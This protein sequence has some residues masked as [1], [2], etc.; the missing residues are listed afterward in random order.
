M[1]EKRVV[2][3]NTHSAYVM[4]KEDEFLYKL[5]Q[6]P[7]RNAGARLT[8]DSRV[9]NVGASH[10]TFISHAADADLSANW[11]EKPPAGKEY[12]AA[13]TEEQLLYE[14]DLPSHHD[15][16]T[17][18]DF[19]IEKEIP[20]LS[21]PVYTGV[22]KE[23]QIYPNE[24][25]FD[26]DYEAEP[27]LQVLMTRILE[28]SRVEV[29]EEE[30]LAAMKQR[31]QQLALHKA[32]VKAQLDRLE[33]QEREAV[34]RNV[35]TPHQKLMKK[36][37][38]EKKKIAIDAHQHLVS[39]AFSKQ[40]LRDVQRDAFDILD[41]QGLFLDEAVRAVRSDFLPWLYQQVCSEVFAHHKVEAVLESTLHSQRPGRCRRVGQP[42]P[43]H[44]HRPGGERTQTPAARRR[45]TTRLGGLRATQ[46]QAG[47][48]AAQ[49]REQETARPRAAVLRRLRGH[50]RH[51]QRHHQPREP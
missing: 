10:Q 39:R 36:R 26:F 11:G 3:G 51:G 43:P 2:R 27:L 18:T 21:M 5:N 48:E 7:A 4:S 29:L 45:R 40:L 14:T 13:Y 25:P 42:G 20:D 34:E 37:E 44:S 49:T 46:T 16:V 33:Q 50:R 23:T 1:F 38:H 31:Q 28:E 15:A 41:C 12:K 32:Q 22:D 17:Q 35:D 9:H 24:P 6:Q 8:V 47:V 30:E 19:V